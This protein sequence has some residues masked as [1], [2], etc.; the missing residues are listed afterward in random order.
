MPFNFF[1]EFQVKTGGYGAEYGRA[2]GGVVSIVTKRGTNEWKGGASV[3]WAPDWGR[4]SGKDVYSRD[5]DLIG[6]V[7]DR[8][9]YRSANESDQ[10]TYNV[11]GSGPLVKDKLFLFGLVQG[12]DNTFDTY[13]AVN[14]TRDSY[15]DPSGMLKLDWNITDNHI[16]ELT[17]IWNKDERE[18][19]TYTFPSVTA[20]R[21]AKRRRGLRFSLFLLQRR[22]S[23]AGH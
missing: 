10:L 12:Q 7:D 21:Y 13:N 3:Y 19:T 16:V 23:P 14:S 18:R 20:K 8:F 5:P 15:T 17:G 22:L 2:L 1:Q 4:E 11:Y 6:T 9:V